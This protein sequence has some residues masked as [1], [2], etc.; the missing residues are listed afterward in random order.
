MKRN[1]LLILSSSCLLLLCSCQ[2]TEQPVNTQQVGRNNDGL[3]SLLKQ[4]DVRSEQPIDTPC[5]H[6]WDAGVIKTVGSC[7]KAEELIYTCTKCNETKVE[8]SQVSGHAMIKHDAVLPTENNDGFKEY[9]TCS[10]EPGVYYKNI[11]GTEKYNSYD[12]IVD[13]VPGKRPNVFVKFDFEARETKKVSLMNKYVKQYYDAKTDDEEYELIHFIKGDDTAKLFSIDNPENGTQ[14][15]GIK[16]KDDGSS[17]YTIYFAT[18]KLFTNYHTINTT[19]NYLNDGILLP[20][21]TYYYCVYGEK[22]NN[23]LDFGTI[24]TEDGGARFVYVPADKITEISSKVYD[25]VPD[26]KY[27]CGFRDIGGWNSTYGVRTPY[28]RIYRGAQLHGPLTRGGSSINEEGKRIASEELGIKTEIDLRGQSESD[29]TSSYIPNAQYVEVAIDQYAKFFDPKEKSHIETI[30]TTLGNENN[31]PV[32][33][34]C[35]AGADRT[36]TV[37]FMLNSLLGVNESE[38]IK[39]YELKTFATSG[40]IRYRDYHTAQNPCGGLDG[41][42]EANDSI[43]AILDKFHTMYPGEKSLPTLMYKVLTEHV[44]VSSILIDNFINLNLGLSVNRNVESKTVSFLNCEM[45][46]ITVKKGS[47]PG[48]LRSPIMNGYIFDHFEYEDGTL[49]NP[50]APVNEDMNLVARW[51]KIGGNKLNA[52]IS[53]WNL[54]DIKATHEFLNEKEEDK[55]EKED[56]AWGGKTLLYTR[57]QVKNNYKVELPKLIYSTSGT[58]S[59]DVV[60]HWETHNILIDDIS[61]GSLKDKQVMNIKIVNGVIYADGTKKGS[62]SYNALFGIEAPLLKINTTKFSKSGFVEVTHIKGGA[63]DYRARIAEVA[64]ELNEVN[65]IADVTSNTLESYKE[66]LT[67]KDSFTPFEKENFVDLL[68]VN[69]KA[70]LSSLVKTIKFYD[71]GVNTGTLFLEAGKPLDVSSPTNH[72]DF[73]FAYWGDEQGNISNVN[74]PVTGDKEFY[75]YYMYESKLTETTKFAKAIYTVTY[76]SYP[77]KN[78]YFGSDE[79]PVIAENSFPRDDYDFRHWSTSATNPNQEINVSSPLTNDVT[80]YAV[81]ENKSSGVLEILDNGGINI[82]T[83]VTYQGI[84][85]FNYVY[86]Q[87]AEEKTAPVHGSGYEFAYWA[88]NGE[89]FDFDTPITESI[90]LNPM[91]YAPSD[92]VTEN[93][94]V[95]CNVAAQKETCKTATTTDARNANGISYLLSGTDATHGGF[96]Q[97]AGRQPGVLTYYYTLPTFKFSDYPLVTFEIKNSWRVGSYYLEDDSVI[98]QNVNTSTFFT[99][100]IK[101]QDM[102]CGTTLVKS[103]LDTDVLNGTKALV[104]KFVCASSGSNDE[105]LIYDYKAY[106]KVVGLSD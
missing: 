63:V 74:G 88:L 80:L 91:Y 48:A 51:K 99:V 106:N 19:R 9:Y 4:T 72:G 67:L 101:G 34:H 22:S 14:N 23:A 94:F 3:Q 43:Y 84:G 29:Q 89:K 83:K 35:T 49:F 41:S 25:V 55:V 85:D 93:S 64:E 71:W 37:S 81:W 68:N 31:Y 15:L 11:Q 96:L 87:K 69:S 86:G 2:G 39:D 5:D 104:I 36:G 12:E 30:L 75:A 58:L 45:D 33:F 21:K 92:E 1:K 95:V 61:L 53:T 59:F 73:Q 7:T 77:E 13:I 42:F 102:Y 40:G 98:K 27:T 54:R 105:T 103:G 79:L 76:D 17:N 44:G 57:S 97:F 50:I 56:K 65:A 24:Q 6:C 46:P 82:E 38:C 16:W 18:N 70:V 10:H 66:Y 78:T 26:D 90:T 8:S 32:Y 47:A 60:D 62:V 20:G 28:G 52:E 100:S